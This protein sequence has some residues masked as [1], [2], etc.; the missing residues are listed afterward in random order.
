MDKKQ[1]KNCEK[2]KI[3]VHNDVWTIKEMVRQ[4]FAHLFTGSSPMA[5][6]LH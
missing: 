4:H 3:N 2:E 5:F 6:K 1:T